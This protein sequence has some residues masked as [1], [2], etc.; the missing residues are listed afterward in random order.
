MTTFYLI[1]Y[2]TELSC[3]QARVAAFLRAENIKRKCSSAVWSVWFAPT[4][5][6]D[7]KLRNCVQNSS[8]TVAI[9]FYMTFIDQICVFHLLESSSYTDNF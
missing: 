9:E 1:Q 3:Q 8:I 5:N 6:Y 7:E 4:A 2:Y